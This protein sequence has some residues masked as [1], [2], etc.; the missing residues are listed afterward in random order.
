[1]Q[2]PAPTGGRLLRSG[3]LNWPERQEPMLPAGRDQMRKR[4]DRARLLAENAEPSGKKV[5]ACVMNS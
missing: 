5:R 1:M 3:R 4:R 2:E